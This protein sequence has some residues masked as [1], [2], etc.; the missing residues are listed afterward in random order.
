[1]FEHFLVEGEDVELTS[2]VSEQSFDVASEVVL[3]VVYGESAKTRHGGGREE[4]IEIIV[5]V[6]V[7]D[8]EYL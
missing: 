3:F 7:H 4:F 5:G 2:E 1:M 8:L 6:D